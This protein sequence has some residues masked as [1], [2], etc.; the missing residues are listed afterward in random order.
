MKG[1][2]PEVTQKLDPGS[3][4]LNKAAEMRLFCIKEGLWLKGKGQGHCGS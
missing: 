3:E 1:V 2:I 4:G